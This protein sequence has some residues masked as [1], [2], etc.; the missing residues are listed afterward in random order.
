MTP[1]TGFVLA[2][3]MNDKIDAL[4]IGGGVV[5]A[6][7][8]YELCA[9]GLQ[10][11][12]LDQRDRIGGETTERNSGVIHAGLYYPENSLKTKLCIAGN[13]LL[14]SWARRY[15]ISHQRC[16]KVILARSSDEEDLLAEEA[17]EGRG[18]EG[19]CGREGKGGCRG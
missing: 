7:V 8:A 2:V 10:C 14:Y 11:W 3:S 18:G 17:R 4:I 6:A 13:E 9:R 12:L 5:G 1:E 16:G 19:G 15:Q